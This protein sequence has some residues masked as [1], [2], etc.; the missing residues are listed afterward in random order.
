MSRSIRVEY[1]KAFYHIIQRGIEKRHIFKEDRDKGKLIEYVAHVHKAY[2]AVIHAYC[3][4]D[5]HYH[6][7]VETPR[8]NIKQIMHSINTSY[9]VFYNKRHRR[10]GPLFQG[11]YKSILVQNDE[12]LWKLSSYIHNNPVKAKLVEK[13]EQYKWSSYPDYIGMRKRS[14]WLEMDFIL[15]NF[16]KGKERAE[17]YAEYVRF[18]MLK[19]EDLEKDI[20]NGFIYGSVDFAKHIIEVY[21][22]GR[23]EERGIKEM[24]AIRS[25][26]ELKSDQVRSVVK[27]YVPDVKEQK[28]IE[29][30]MLRKYTSR[31]N[32][33]ISEAY[34]GIG[35]HAV[36]KIYTRIRDRRERD[37]RLDKILKRIEEKMS[38][39]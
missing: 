7:I 28:K 14:D 32:E 2:G 20:R 17:R 26:L 8:A 19:D 15:N 10:V 39:V 9:A 27:K 31:K 5:N 6:F 30:Y 4:L 35:M 12:Y 16:G 18:N 13:P 37:H 24:S 36:S 22:T 38:N 21:L 29:M 11:R 25:E 23:T 33:E 1:E 3:I 34:E